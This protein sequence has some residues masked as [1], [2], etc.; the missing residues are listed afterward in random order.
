MA[1]SPA[2]AADSSVPLPPTVLRD[3]KV[4]SLRI[5]DLMPRRHSSSLVRDILATIRRYGTLPVAHAPILC[6]DREDPSFF[7]PCDGGH[8]VSAILEALREGILGAEDIIR[9]LVIVDQDEQSVSLCDSRRALLAMEYND[10]GHNIARTTAYDSITTDLVFFKAWSAETATELSISSAAEYAAGYTTKQLYVSCKVAPT[11]FGA[12]LTAVGT[13][14]KAVFTFL[15]SPRALQFLGKTLEEGRFEPLTYPHYRYSLTVLGAQ[16]LRKPL[17]PGSSADERDQARCVLLRVFEAWYD[18]HMG[19]VGD[20]PR[21][22]EGVE[23]PTLTVARAKR[24]GDTFVFFLRGMTQAAVI[25]G[26]S[27]EGVLV[28]HPGPAADVP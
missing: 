1:A 24:I 3:V 18:V 16:S 2:G 8:R 4:G 28:L 9:A 15:E 13:L 10:Q 27:L 6:L 11:T 20:T 12:R 25:A 5:P 21:P 19:I 26:W 22:W 17:A 7:I 23:H 14:V